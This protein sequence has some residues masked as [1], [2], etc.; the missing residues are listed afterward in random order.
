MPAPGD[1]RQQSLLARAGSLSVQ[2]SLNGV[3]FLPVQGKGIKHD[4]AADRDN[5]RKLPEDGPITG[6][7]EQRFS[8]AELSEGRAAGFEFVHAAQR[9]F[10]NRLRGKGVE[11]NTR[12]ILERLGIL[13]QRELDFNALGGFKHSRRGK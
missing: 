6:Q 12:A 3:R 13:K 1:S 2:K 4:G 5:G 9:Y 8:R 7:Q 10:G 11:M